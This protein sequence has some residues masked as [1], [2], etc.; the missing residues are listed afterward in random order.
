MRRQRLYKNGNYWSYPVDIATEETMFI[1]IKIIAFVFWCAYQVILKLAF[2]TE[3]KNTKP[4]IRSKDDLE[5]CRFANKQKPAQSQTPSTPKATYRFFSPTC[6]I[7]DEYREQIAHKN[8]H[9]R[10]F[11]I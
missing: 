10:V 2:N 3:T 4:I 11:S 9:R 6:F 7:S 1:I 8:R 5:L